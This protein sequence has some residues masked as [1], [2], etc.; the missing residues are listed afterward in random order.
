MPSRHLAAAVVVIAGLAA[1]GGDDG[2]DGAGSDVAATT[3]AAVST[4]EPGDEPTDATA[5]TSGRPSRTFEASPTQP[6]L[7]SG[8]TTPPVAPGVPVGA[9]A[10]AN[11]TAAVADLAARLGVDPA[12]VR[13]V[14]EQNVTWRN[15]AIGCPEPGVGYLDRLVDGV[16]IVLEVAGKEY[17]YHAGGSRSIFYCER[18]QLP[19]D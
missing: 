17:S 19:G 18:P 4:T 9:D 15:S 12:E 2:P 8:A 5:T 16:R 6:T 14:S 1:C 13:L 11:V 10:S 7:D 3:V